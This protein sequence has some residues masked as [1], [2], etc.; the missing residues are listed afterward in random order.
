MTKLCFM[1]HK[2]QKEILLEIQ[3]ICADTSISGQTFDY[4]DYTA[5]I[6]KLIT[7]AKALGVDTHEIEGNLNE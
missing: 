4:D 3:S 2:L 7:I 1:I 6:T 5:S